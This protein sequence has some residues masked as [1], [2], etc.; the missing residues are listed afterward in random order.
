MVLAELWFLKGKE[1]LTV[2]IRYCLSSDN[3]S[4]VELK[5]HNMLLS[6][7]QICVFHILSIIYVYPLRVYYELTKMTSSQWA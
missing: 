5:S 3:N 6:A 1:N 4:C 2:P 7:V